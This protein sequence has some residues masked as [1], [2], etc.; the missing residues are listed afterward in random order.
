MIRKKNDIFMKHSR[1]KFKKRSRKKVGFVKKFSG[2]VMTK[3]RHRSP[4]AGERKHLFPNQPMRSRPHKAFPLCSSRSR[5]RAIVPLHC[6][7][8]V[9]IRYVCVYIGSDKPY[10]LPLPFPL[11]ARIRHPIP[12]CYHP[13]VIV[14]SGS[15]LNRP[16]RHAS[17]G[18]HSSRH[19][20]ASI[21]LLRRVSFA[22]LF[23][24]HRQ[25]FFFFKILVKNKFSFILT[26]TRLSY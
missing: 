2:C 21:L 22:D 13:S 12:Q 20:L 25:I 19:V 6:L 17:F 15:K 11:C 24:K 3:T 14:V 8:A 1:I 23:S 18:S 9:P 4:S 16:Y 26:L 10:F 5:V 7:P